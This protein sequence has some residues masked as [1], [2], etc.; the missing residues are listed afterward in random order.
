MLC[1]TTKCRVIYGDTDHRGIA[2]HANYLRWFEIGRT[3]MFRSLSLTYKEVERKGLFLPVARACCD[4]I[5]PAR[6]DDLLSI[7]TRLDPTFKAGVRFDYR[8][9][10]DG[11]NRVS[12]TGF[13][14]HACVNA[15]GK[16]VRPPAFI[17]KIIQTASKEI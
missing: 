12:A 15:H 13:T 5:S 17:R 7:E 8:V 1:H 9:T 2:C 3:E 14:R 11:E 6:Y 16:V 4:F 10:V